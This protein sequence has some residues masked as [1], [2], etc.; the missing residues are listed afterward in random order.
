MKHTT[1]TEKILQ[2]R[3]GKDSLIA[4]ATTENGVPFVRNVNALYHDGSFFVL[5]YALSAKMRQIEQNPVVA[6][7]GEWFSAQ[8]VARN[9]GWFC[10]AENKEI[11]HKMKKAFASW[12]DN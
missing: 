4:L 3:F 10:K 9:S 1:E 11:A 2:E 12:I 5:T 8:G 7:C 6:I